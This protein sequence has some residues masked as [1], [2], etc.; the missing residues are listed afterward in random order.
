MKLSHASGYAIQTLVSLASQEGGDLVAAPHA[1]QA[2]GMPERFLAKVLKPLV[3]V[4]ILHSKKG[5]GGGYGLA[6]PPKRI[7]LLEVVE[8]VDGPLGGQFPHIQGKGTDALEG[9][10]REVWAQVIGPA[11]KLLGKVSLAQ[12]AGTARPRGEE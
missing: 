6:K 5:P 11:R 1:A 10:L 8:A 9:R 4:G 12:L 7:T 2:H 3:A